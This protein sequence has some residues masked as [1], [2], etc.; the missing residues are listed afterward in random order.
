MFGAGSG[1]L[2]LSCPVVMMSLS[3]ALPNCCWSLG[4]HQTLAEK[5]GES[6]QKGRREKRKR[7]ECGWQM[8]QMWDWMKRKSWVLGGKRER[9]KKGLRNDGRERGRVLSE[10]EEQMRG[11]GCALTFFDHW[12][13]HVATEFTV[14]AF[15]FSSWA[16][17]MCVK[18]KAKVSPHKFDYTKQK[19][20][21][22]YHRRRIML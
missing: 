14:C 20:M 13:Q 12:C 18:S 3:P 6:P 11:A 17:W 7:G 22:L 2:S 8:R 21:L 9:K 15:L 1:L 19:H 10:R 4:G 5:G 16:A